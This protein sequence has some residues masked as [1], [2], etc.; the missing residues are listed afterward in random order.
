MSI[1]SAGLSFTER[2][3]IGVQVKDI[4]ADVNRVER[5]SLGVAIGYSSPRRSWVTVAREPRA[6]RV[7]GDA[8]TP[9]LHHG[10]SGWL[11]ELP[12]GRHVIEIEDATVASAAVDVVSVLSSRSIVWL[13]GRFVLLLGG[14][15]AAVRIRRS[16]RRLGASAKSDSNKAASAAL[17]LRDSLVCAAPGPELINTIERAIPLGQHGCSA[18][19]EPELVGVGEVNH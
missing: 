10:G 18:E 5:T 6:V 3:G 1:E 15:Y 16:I 14:L 11:V 4:S 7:D 9:F 19:S 2:L 8:I 17:P 13:G 12:A